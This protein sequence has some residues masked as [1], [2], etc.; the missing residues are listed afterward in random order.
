[1]QTHTQVM[2]RQTSM[3]IMLQANL[4]TCEGLHHASTAS[5]QFLGLQLVN[6]NMFW[7]SRNGVLG[8]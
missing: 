8:D 2:P 5:K 3:Q 7:A 6:R 1:M 4:K